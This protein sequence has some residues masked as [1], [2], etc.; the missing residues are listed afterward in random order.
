MTEKR[1]LPGSTACREKQ[2]VL[3][4]CLTMKQLLFSMM[5]A[6]TAPTISEL[7]QSNQTRREKKLWPQRIWISSPWLR[8]RPGKGNKIIS[9]SST[10]ANDASGSAAR[11]G[12]QQKISNLMMILMFNKP[13][14]D[15]IS[16]FRLVDYQ[17]KIY[18]IK[19]FVFKYHLL[20]EICTFIL[21]PSK[22][23]VDVC[24]FLIQLFMKLFHVHL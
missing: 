1:E 9:L 6:T 11:A 7:S 3:K 5:C 13:L 18:F 10:V 2:Y 22:R 12:Y 19:N 8:K 17:K 15:Q 14:V 23:P 24:L 4:L 16:R 21:H 20:R